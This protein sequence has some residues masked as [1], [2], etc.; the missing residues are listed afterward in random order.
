VGV[1]ANNLVVA[2][3][4]DAGGAE[5]VS[6]YTATIDFGDGTTGQGTITFANGIFRVTA[7]HT[8]SNQGAY[9]ITATIKDEGGST[10][11]ATS[12]TAVGWIAGVYL[13]LLHRPIDPAGLTAWNTLLTQG[14][15]RQQIVAD[16][17]TSLEYRTDEVQALYVQ[18]LHR[19][20]EPF[21]LNAYVNALGSGLT[22][23]Q[24]EALILRSPEFFKDAGGTNAGF[25]T[26]LYQDLL[27]RSPDSFGMTAF[28]NAL[29][30][31]ASRL[32]VATAILSGD[33]CHQDLIKSIYLQYLRRNA[34]SFGLTGFTQAMRTL[35][36]E[37]LIAIVLGSQEYFALAV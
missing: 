25:L 30:T 35:S 34:D 19:N 26:A 6:N 37:A 7:S 23:A 5:A 10:V 22:L 18:F 8:Y 2:T 28:L 17:E 31:G 36:E 32:A 24:V 16:I 12:T 14:V 4:T 13:D 33:E 29:N 1:A 3:F 27:N 11:T 20:A 15:S 21:G 9:T